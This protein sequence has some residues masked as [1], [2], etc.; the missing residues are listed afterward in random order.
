MWIQ[1]GEREARPCNAKAREFPRGEVDDI[2]EQV[3]GQ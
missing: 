2:A 1:S 3:A